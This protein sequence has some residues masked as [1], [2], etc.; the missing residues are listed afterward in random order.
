MFYLVCSLPLSCR[1]SSCFKSIPVDLSSF[2]RRS[3]VQTA[4]DVFVIPDATLNFGRWSKLSARV[5][6]VCSWAR[7]SLVVFSQPFGWTFFSVCLI[8]SL[9]FQNFFDFF[10]GQSLPFV[11]LVGIWFTMFFTFCSL[12]K[13]AKK[14]FPFILLAN[15]ILQTIIELSLDVFDPACS[16]TFKWNWLFL[17]KTNFKII[18]LHSKLLFH[19]L[20]WSSAFCC[21]SWPEKKRMSLFFV[22]HFKLDEFFQKTF[23]VAL[24]L[25][26]PKYA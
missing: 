18:T 14:D 19:K 17:I 21:L 1:L 3:L 26:P 9:L 11:W 13:S 12:L 24:H 20:I 6:C 25:F 8:F 4:T 15:R 5:V 16:L 10:R 2:V 23:L 22:L 7:R